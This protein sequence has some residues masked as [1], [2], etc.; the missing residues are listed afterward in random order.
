MCR[1]ASVTCGYARGYGV[2][3]AC[4]V[5]VYVR[6]MYVVYDVCGIWHV[7]VTAMHVGA[8]YGHGMWHMHVHAC[9]LCVRCVW[10]V[11]CM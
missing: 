10:Q 9:E 5:C 11:A 8:V 4:G 7:C 6:E 2:G 3:A 1:V